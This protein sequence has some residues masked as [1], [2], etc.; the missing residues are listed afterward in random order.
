MKNIIFLIS[1]NPD[2]R[3]MKRIAL[4]SENAIVTV[5]Y[6]PRGEY[7]FKKIENVKF[8]P[9]EISYSKYINGTFD[10][11]KRFFSLM[12]FL[13][14][15]LKQLNLQTIDIIHCG[16]IDMLFLAYM[17][18]RKMKKNTKIIYEVADFHRLIFVER[19]NIISIIKSFFYKN[20]EK[21]LI[22]KVNNLVLTSIQHYENYYSTIYHGKVTL[23]PNAPSSNLFRKFQEHTL[24]TLTI[25]VIGLIRDKE[26]IINLID[27]AEITGAKVIIAGTGFSEVEFIKNYISDKK[28]T[29][30]YGPYDYENEILELYSRVDIVFSVFDI[31]RPNIR[32]C[33][34]NRLYEAIACNKPLIVP[35]ETFMGD[36]VNESGVGFLVKYN[37]K[38]ELIELLFELISNKTIINSKKDNIRKIEKKHF[39]DFSDDLITAYAE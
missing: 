9:L 3:F 37:D 5:Y 30:F 25:G 7:L 15:F 17:Y 1:H 31:T 18:K 28:N 4:A 6:I 13:N 27:A 32:F 22:R 38:E 14:R 2:P 16:N 35:K 8:V 20:L 36:Y 33:M 10:I 21:K 23:L 11:V 39:E 29:Y 26:Q 24:N 19:N 34:P 12:K